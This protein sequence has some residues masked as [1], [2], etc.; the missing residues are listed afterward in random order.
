M[1][2]T[3]STT[4]RKLQTATRR[5]YDL[6]LTPDVEIVR[7]QDVDMDT[8]AVLADYFFEAAQRRHRSAQV[9]HVPYCP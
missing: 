9:S 6:L 2:S 4:A 1:T 3:Y 5:L 8:F 7:P